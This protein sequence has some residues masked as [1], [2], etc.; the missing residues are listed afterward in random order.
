MVSSFGLNH[1]DFPFNPSVFEKKT[2]ILITWNLGSIFPI[3]SFSKQCYHYLSLRILSILLSCFTVCNLVDW[4][5]IAY[6]W[7]VSVYYYYEGTVVPTKSDSDINFCL[8]FLSQ[9]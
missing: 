3:V 5:V 7:V 1:S 2:N 6:I 9:H 4:D 8:Q